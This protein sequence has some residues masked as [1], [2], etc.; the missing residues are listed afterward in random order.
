M[1]GRGSKSDNETIKNKYEKSMD[2]IIANLDVNK[3]LAYVPDWFI[4]RNFNSNERYSMSIADNVY[5][6]RETEKAYHVVWETEHGNL[7]GWIPKS[8]VSDDK[9]RG[10]LKENIEKQRRVKEGLNYNEKL[11]KYAKDNKVKGIRKGMKTKTLIEKI[12]NQ[13][14]EVPKRK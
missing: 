9:I 10:Y 2:K 6:D 13:G 8:I 1:G 7:N 5:S 3:R 14:L 4:E 12:R 11:V